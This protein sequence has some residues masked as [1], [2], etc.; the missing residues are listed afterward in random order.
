L[1]TVVIPVYRN[2]GSIPELLDVV[3]G[4]NANLKGE[5]EA[6]F[7]VDG[8]PDRC[9]EILL[10]TL[11]TRPFRAKLALLSRNFGSFSAIRAGLETGEGK[12]F[13]VMAADLQEPPGLVLEMAGV[14]RSGD[15][16]VAVGVREKRE[17]PLMARI[18]SKIFWGLY[19]R[20]VIPEIPSGGVDIFACTQAFRDQLLQME[21]RH[22]SIIA[23]IFWLGYRRKFITYSRRARKHG[24]SAWTLGKKINYLTDSVFSFTDL[25]IRLLIRG[26]AAA[27]VVSGLLG[28]FVVISRLLGLITVR[29]YAATILAIMFFGA[30]NL[31]ALGTVGSY[32]WRTYENTKARPLH[33]ILRSHVFDPNREK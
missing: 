17:D 19:R 18:P 26:G 11:P 8:S 32:A 29:G 4:L 24:N 1:L 5:F 28:L 21:E 3:E 6:V 12:Y 25:P 13:A 31:L 15:I 2:E 30:L 23:E 33:V 7:V 16:D 14:L 27:V 20:F 9:Y 22:S 10:N